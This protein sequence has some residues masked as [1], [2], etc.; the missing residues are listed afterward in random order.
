ML[1][2]IFEAP[3]PKQIQISK[4]QIQDYFEQWRDCTTLKGRTHMS[5]LSSLSLLSSARLPRPDCIGTRNDSEGLCSQW[6]PILSL[7]GTPVPK[8]SCGGYKIDVLRLAC[9]DKRGSRNYQKDVA[10]TRENEYKISGHFLGGITMASPVR[11]ILPFWLTHTV[12]RRSLFF[13]CK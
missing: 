1:N 8:Q 7:R 11:A 4:F 12:S 5:S 9:N 10:M 13:S 6:H 3:N 2:P